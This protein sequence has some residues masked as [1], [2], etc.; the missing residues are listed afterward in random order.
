MIKFRENIE[1]P[2]DS[3]RTKFE[4]VHE[5]IDDSSNVVHYRFI[6][7]ADSKIKEN[8]NGFN[9]KLIQQSAIAIFELWLM[10]CKPYLCRMLM[11]NYVQ[12]W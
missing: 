12:H 5:S 3:C 7:D 1:L 11:T 8:L 9:N 10:K 6:G 4:L 2:S